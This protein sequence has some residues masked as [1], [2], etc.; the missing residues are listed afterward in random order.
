MSPLDPFSWYFTENQ[1]G[2]MKTFVSLIPQGLFYLAA[3]GATT[4][5]KWGLAALFDFAA[6]RKRKPE[7]LRM[8]SVN[9][10]RLN[11]L[12]TER[13][14]SWLCLNKSSHTGGDTRRTVCST[15][16]SFPELQSPVCR[17]E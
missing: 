7:A 4:L 17:V 13:F 8:F 15:D 3:A 1:G 12:Y 16:S 11:D 9:A 2:D 10:Q 6:M 14:N 5:T